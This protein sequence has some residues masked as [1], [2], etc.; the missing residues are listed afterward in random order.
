MR[1]Y[2]FGVYLREFIHKKTP[3]TEE[4]IMS[5]GAGDSDSCI[6]TMSPPP[7][8]STT[9]N[10]DKECGD[11]S[12]RSDESGARGVCTLSSRTAPQ[13]TGQLRKCLKNATSFI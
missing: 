3:L 12:T 13:G 5:F 4:G 8:S 6:I 2:I 1:A 11:A 7:T 10:Q 9:E